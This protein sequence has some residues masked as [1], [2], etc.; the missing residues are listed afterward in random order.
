VR[1]L[2]FALDRDVLSGPVNVVAPNPVRMAALAMAIGRALH[3]PAAVRVPAGALR[4]A[5]G[6]GLAQALLT[7]Q[8]ALPRKLLETGFAFDFAHVDEACAEALR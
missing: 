8:R 2:L 7:G 4:L 6:R 1:A 5:L 3:R